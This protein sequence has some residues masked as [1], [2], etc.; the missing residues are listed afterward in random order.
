MPT[1]VQSAK[2]NTVSAPVGIKRVV[3]FILCF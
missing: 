2:K 3:M 1:F